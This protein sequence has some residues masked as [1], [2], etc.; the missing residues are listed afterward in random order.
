VIQGEADEAARR[1]R[2]GREEKRGG[3]AV[4]EPPEAKGNN[5]VSLLFLPRMQIPHQ[6]KRRVELMTFLR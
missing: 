1:G 4:R 6:F 5:L 2:G 3:W